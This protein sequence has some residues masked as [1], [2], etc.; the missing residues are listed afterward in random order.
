M[1]DDNFTDTTKNLCDTCKHD[2]AICG[3]IGIEFGNGVGGDNVCKCKSYTAKTNVIPG[4]HQN[5]DEPVEY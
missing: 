5:G 1:S 2:F 4:H 3:G